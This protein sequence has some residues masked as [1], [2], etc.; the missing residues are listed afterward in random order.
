MAMAYAFSS[1]D[2]TEQQAANH[3][4]GIV[5]KEPLGVFVDICI[6]DLFLPDEFQAHHQWWV[7]D[8]RDLLELC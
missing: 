4:V 5:A 8:R 1:E 7:Q 3:G 6:Q 2:M